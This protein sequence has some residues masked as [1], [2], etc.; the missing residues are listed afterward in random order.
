VPTLRRSQRSQL[1]PGCN[2]ARRKRSSPTLDSLTRK[3]QT[4]AYGHRHG[5]TVSSRAAARCHKI[6]SDMSMRGWSNSW[7]CS[8]TATVY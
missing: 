7:R 8:F 1:K 2:P 5:Y 3:Y 6:D 4:E